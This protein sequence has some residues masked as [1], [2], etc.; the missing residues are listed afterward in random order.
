MMKANQKNCSTRN[1]NDVKFRVIINIFRQKQMRFTG[2][3]GEKK[4]RKQNWLINR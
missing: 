4:R 1:E 2:K 3:T